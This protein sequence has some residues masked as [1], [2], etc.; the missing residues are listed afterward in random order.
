M[1]PVAM[2]LLAACL[3]L[4]VVT[5]PVLAER[6]ATISPNNVS[7]PDYFF[8][9]ILDYR[10]PD[11]KAIGFVLPNRA[12]KAPLRQYAMAVDEV[13]ALTGYDFYPNLEDN[14]ENRP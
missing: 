5:G 12:S 11:Y 6:L 2:Y 4:Y 8:K 13:E 7:V 9:V 3:V 10:A 1:R 14:L